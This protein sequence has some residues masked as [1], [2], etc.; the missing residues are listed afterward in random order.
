MG[1]RYIKI[2]DLGLVSYEEALQV[3]SELHE[4]LNLFNKEGSE[5][6]FHSFIGYI[7]LCEHP[8]V[9]TIGT[10]GVDSHFLIDEKRLLEINASI[11]RANRGGDITYHGPG[12]LVVYFILDLNYICLDLHKYLR[13]LEEIVI[14]ALEAFEIKAGRINS[15]TGVWIKEEEMDR[16]ICAIGIR[17]KNWVT[18]HGIALNVNTDL[19][20]FDH[21][22]PCGIRNKGVTS[23]RHILNQIQS[24]EFVSQRIIDISK[25]KFEVD[26]VFI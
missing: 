19:S 7:I 18:M 10:S 13:L 6:K 26:I 2:I 9:Y 20:Y 17:V 22:V 23:M 4:E 25:N 12:Q 24:L 1:E 8:H 14:E 15:L 11:Y 5:I 16:K 21:I 3:Q